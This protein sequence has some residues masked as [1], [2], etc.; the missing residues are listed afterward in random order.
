MIRVSHLKQ[1]HLHDEV[2]FFV[3]AVQAEDYKEAKQ[4]LINIR[5]L[6]ESELRRIEPVR[7]DS[8]ETSED[9]E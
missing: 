1:K 6:A 9:S 4:A 3:E 7:G 5:W 8:E 2:R